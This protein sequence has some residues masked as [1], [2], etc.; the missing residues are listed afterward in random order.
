VRIGGEPSI[1]PAGGVAGW[2]PGG[3]AVSSWGGR[4]EVHREAPVAKSQFVAELEEEGEAEGQGTGAGAGGWG[5]EAEAEAA[6]RSARL[7]AAAALLSGPRSQP[8]LGPAAVSTVEGVRYWTDFLKA[9]LHPRS[10]L[11][12]PGTRHGV[13]DFSGYGQGRAAAAPG[14]EVLEEL[15]ERVRLL[16]ERCD[17]LQGFQVLVDDQSGFGGVAASLLQEVRQEYGSSRPVALFSLRSQTESVMPGVGTGVHR[18]RAALNAALALADLSE[19][20]SLYIPLSTPAPLRNSGLSHLRYT[21]SSAFET[22]AVLAAAVDSALLPVRLMQG[23]AS[24][25]GTAVGGCN[26]HSLAKLLTGRQQEQP[27]VAMSTS[28]PAPH[29]PDDTQQLQLMAGQDLRLQH[30]HM[31]GVEVAP[32]SPAAACAVLR[33]T[34]EPAL[35]SLTP[36]IKDLSAADCLA[37]CVVFRGQAADWTALRRRPC[38]HRASTTEPERLTPRRTQALRSAASCRAVGL[39]GDVS[40]QPGIGERL[41]GDVHSV[42]V[43]TKLLATSAFEGWTQAVVKQWRAASSA[44]SGKALLDGWGFESSDVS[45]LTESLKR[46]SV[47]QFGAGRV[48]MVDE[49]RTSRVSSAYSHP[50]EALPGQPPESFR[51]LR[52]VY[53]EAKRSQVRGLMCSTSNNIRFYDRDVS[54]ALNIRRCAVGPGPRP[55]ELCYWA[56]RPAMPKPGSLGQEC[57]Y[58]LKLGGLWNQLTSV[59]FWKPGSMN[60]DSCC[61]GAHALALQLALR[62]AR[63]GSLHACRLTCRAWSRI[64]PAW[65]ADGGLR[66]AF[67]EDSGDAWLWL[68]ASSHTLPARLV[69]VVESQTSDAL[70]Q[71]CHHLSCTSQAQSASCP[72]CQHSSPDSGQAPAL[73]LCHVTLF[74]AEDVA[75]LVAPTGPA[76]QSAAHLL[77]LT[78]YGGYAITPQHLVMSMA[79]LPAVTH[80]HLAG[81]QVASWLEA[82]RVAPACLKRLEALVLE[83]WLVRPAHRLKLVGLANLHQLR[84]LA[85]ELR[86]EDP[87]GPP[88]G[89][90]SHTAMTPRHAFAHTAASKQTTAKMATILKSATRSAVRAG[91]SR[92]QVSVQARRT[93]APL[94]SSDSIWYGPERPLFLGPFTGEPPSYLS[95]EFAGDYGWDTAGLSADPETFRRYR[96]IEVIHARWA[97]LGALGIV[98]PEILAANGV[99]LEGVWFKAGAEIF[100]EGGLNYLGNENLVHAQSI[101]ATLAVQVILMGLA[102]GYRVNGGP[103]GK[104]A[105]NQACLTRLLLT[106]QPY[107]AHLPVALCRPTLA[108]DVA[109][110]GEGLD[111]LH[112]G[113]A[114]DPLGLADDPDTFAELKVKE[115]KNGR[116]AMFSCFGFFV[117][118]IVTGKGPIQNLTDHLANPGANNAFAYATNIYY[119]LQAACPKCLSTTYLIGQMNES[120]LIGQINGAAERRRRCSS[121]STCGKVQP[122]HRVISAA[123][124][125]N[126]DIRASN[127]MLTLAGLTVAQEVGGSCCWRMRLDSLVTRSRQQ[128]CWQPWDPGRGE[129]RER[130]RLIPG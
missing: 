15:G 56:G 14:G 71:L 128:P 54:A 16:A 101:I 124:E 112:P 26:M 69:V 80:L 68:T 90:E 93:K 50:S 58:G 36:G 32:G 30:P 13:S 48:V 23:A 37:E 102:E 67:G 127:G 63:L 46:S 108:D 10:V 111:P 65:R 126:H 85:F 100:K 95:G 39:H 89:F 28:L 113:G 8:H 45:E 92:R 9:Q 4:L 59:Q 11:C 6:E 40:L 74:T 1:A 122:G 77:A 51:W 22:A 49:F 25:C 81:P 79:R 121:S 129:W 53:S 83:E 106:F 82:V 120:N 105:Y 118:A 91:V 12:L 61:G 29:L 86:G 88:L 64:I 123:F 60:S 7:A 44:P 117:Q 55:T 43:L 33:N 2:Q 119:E 78:V 76:A 98:T 20:V 62:H 5:A 41:A 116:L 72:V 110:A 107:S 52:P 18:E 27:L 70:H 35:A 42:P 75:W 109:Y 125:G 38:H 99:P 47:R 57:V 21:S 66:V 103:L 24:P 114:F 34:T 31:A 130:Q 73:A 3:R 96:T 87:R 84:R 104:L 19:V 97:L 94:K 115:I 17:A